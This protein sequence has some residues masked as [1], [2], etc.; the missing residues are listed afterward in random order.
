MSNDGFTY[1][2]IIERVPSPDRHVRVRCECTLCGAVVVARKS[3]VTTKAIKSCGCH[4]R[5]QPKL[6]DTT[7]GQEINDILFVGYISNSD[8]MVIYKCGHSGVLTPSRAAKAKTGLCNYCSNR[9][10]TTMSHGLTGTP[11]YV[12]WCNMRR[13]CYSESNNRYENY[14]A[15]GIEVC[16]EWNPLNGGSFE[17]FYEDMGECPEGFSLER[18]D[19]LKGYNKNNCI[20]A[21]DITQANNKSNNILIKDEKGTTWSLRRWCE[22]LGKD[23]KYAWHQIRN[24]GLSIKTVLG[25]DYEIIQIS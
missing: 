7:T 21:D 20:W 19:L 22:I 13:R 3:H 10:P 12:S 2:S 16:D 18:K 8:W 15:L 6:P 17:K 24:K 23:Y 25:E 5:L 9:L 4:A 11:T 14:G 1:L